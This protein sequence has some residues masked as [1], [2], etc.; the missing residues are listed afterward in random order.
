MQ[1]Q[2]NIV[3]S[4]YGSVWGGFDEKMLARAE[5]NRQFENSDID[6]DWD[7]SQVQDLSSTDESSK[8]SISENKIFE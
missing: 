3:D 5:R 2:I 4:S 1:S 8:N 6:S 7:M